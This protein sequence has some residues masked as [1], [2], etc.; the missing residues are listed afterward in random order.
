MQQTD[1]QTDR[2]TSP[3]V[4]LTNTLALIL[5]IGFAAFSSI[6][7]TGCG[8]DAGGS[9]NPTDTGS[10]T[11]ADRIVLSNAFNAVAP[12][13]S[14]EN[15]WNTTMTYGYQGQPSYYSQTFNTVFFEASQHKPGKNIYSTV[16]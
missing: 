10:S 13:I 7:L 9:G 14:P 15:I 11:D 1:R 8:G 6:T 4:K 3:S 16:S 12:A 2:Q 5:I